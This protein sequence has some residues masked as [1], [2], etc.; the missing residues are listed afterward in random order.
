[1]HNGV[2]IFLIYMCERSDAMRRL[3]LLLLALMLITLP[4]LSS[5]ENISS[6]PEANTESCVQEWLLFPAENEGGISPVDVQ[7]GYIRYIAQN[8]EKDPLFCTDYWCSV[9]KGDNFD[10]TAKKSRKGRTFRDYASTMCTRAAYAMA[11]SYLGYSETPGDMSVM[12]NDRNI[13]DPYDAVTG[14]L[15]DLERITYKSNVFERMMDNY[16]TDPSYSPV[17]LYFRKPNGV[18]HAVLVVGK[19]DEEGYY[20][21]LDP[22]IHYN[23]K[24]EIVRVYRIRF[25]VHYRR[26]I[27][28]TFR[29]EQRDS[30][31][32]SFCQWH[33]TN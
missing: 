18:Y 22:A 9:D 6:L 13:D 28:S 25:D 23:K 4:V 3:M 30:R 2:Q 17:Y 21:V 26:I 10:L 29:S 31:V 32:V 12:V 11:L 1:M 14:L 19:A 16:L 24:K 8:K 15:P 7:E 33:R 20:L 27:N 5:A